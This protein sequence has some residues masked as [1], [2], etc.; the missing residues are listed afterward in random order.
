MIKLL[1]EY[2]ITGEYHKSKSLI[3]VNWTL[4]NCFKRYITTFKPRK[5]ETQKLTAEQSQMK[6]NV[7]FTFFRSR[8]GARKANKTRKVKSAAKLKIIFRFTNR[9]LWHRDAVN[10]NNDAGFQK[11]YW[12]EI[13][14]S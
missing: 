6:K 10:P 12:I 8:D 13:N 3:S 9:C 1:K 2:Y 7:S 4:M 14:T 11:W 5:V